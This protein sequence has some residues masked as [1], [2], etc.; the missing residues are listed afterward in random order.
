M[1]LVTIALLGASAAAEPVQPIRDMPVVNPRESEP[2]TC[3]AISRYEASGR[4]K[5]PK[6]QKLNELP[7]ADMYNA[8]YRRIGGCEVPIVVKYGVSGR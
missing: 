8:V 3:P 6:A 4:N 2:G 7:D 5:K 1:L